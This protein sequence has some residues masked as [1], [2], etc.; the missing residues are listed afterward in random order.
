MTLG[1]TIQRLRKDK[2]I[3]VL[4]IMDVLNISQPTYSRI[5]TGIRELNEDELKKIA[6]KIGMT[7]EE[8]LEEAGITINI[9]YNTNKTDGNGSS[10]SGVVYNQTAPIEKELYDNLLAEKET[11]LIEK[12]KQLQEKNE[13]LIQQAEQ[14]KV[15]QEQNQRLTERL[16]E[17]R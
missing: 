3:D 10:G 14:I 6:D 9:R 17:L 11:R 7:P 16:L 5:E 4:E 1:K 13:Q 8:I 15:L 2:K 12:D